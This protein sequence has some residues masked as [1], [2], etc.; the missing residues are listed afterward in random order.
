MANIYHRKDGRWEARIP[1]GSDEAGRRRYRSVYGKTREE[2]EY[3]LLI[4]QQPTDDSVTE[5]TVREL[6]V[7]WLQQAK[8][9]L[10]ASTI[11]N[12]RM[13]S[14]RHILP[15]FGNTLCC[16]LNSRMIYDFIEKKLSDG[17]SPR[18]VAD[19]V[20][21][22]K[23][24]FRYASREYHV[25]NVLDG[26][27]LPKCRKPEPVLLN[28]EQLN[29]L[30]AYLAANPSL[31]TMG[32]ALSVYTGIRI[33]ELCALK[34]ADIDLEKRLLSVR[35]TIQRVQMPQGD[36]RT[37][38]VITEPKSHNSIREIPIPVC[39]CEMFRK[40][41]GKP[42]SF[43]LSGTIKPVEPRTMQYR[44]AKLLQNADLPSVHFHSLRHAFASGCI[45][46]GFDVKTLSEIL[47]HS[48][49]E[50]TLNRYVHTS[51]DR[52]RA[53]MDLLDRPA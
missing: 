35:K 39:L 21:L 37:S 42:D 24:M 26:I 36:R 10:K 2:A 29:H 44:F 30:K 22:M 11:A 52:K 38:L 7:E 3:K 53:C 50:L 32:V 16:R 46:L 18:Y 28:A 27:V 15:A 51:L 12:Y 14:E 41:V 4:S 47:G 19:I 8:L 31:T 17:L 45:A 5:M 25:R 43:V 13:K 1:L 48:S 23:S 40:Y 33:G 20:V 9:R 6:T 49:I 34:W